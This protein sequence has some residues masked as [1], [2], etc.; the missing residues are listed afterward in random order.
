M[1]A[2]GELRALSLRCGAAELEGGALTKQPDHG[3]PDLV[4]KDLMQGWGST[5]G[6]ASRDLIHWTAA[7][8]RGPRTDA[9]AAAADSLT[10]RK[11]SRSRN[12]SSSS[13]SAKSGRGLSVVFLGCWLLS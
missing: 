13:S 7:L 6:G 3:N 5:A 2:R 4:T 10:T 9:A 8:C 1:S 11:K 12:K